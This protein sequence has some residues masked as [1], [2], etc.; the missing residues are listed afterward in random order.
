[1]EDITLLSSQEPVP[2]DTSQTPAVSS[3]SGSSNE[4]VHEDRSKLGRKVKN[5]EEQL[6]TLTR[7]IEEQKSLIEHLMSAKQQPE[8]Y[9]ESAPEEEIPDVPTTKDDVLKIIQYYEKKKTAEEMKRR[10]NYEKQY[11][12]TLASLLSSEDP[13]LRD[14]IYRIW[15]S[16]YNRVFTNDPVVDAEKGFLLA[17]VEALQKLSMSSRKSP[18]QYPTT[19]YST[20]VAGIELSPEARKLAKYLGFTEDDIREAMESKVIESSQHLIK[21]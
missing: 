8:Q 20:H 2:E 21:K 11:S 3:T 18:P 6:R 15:V 5:L 7:V 4:N 16:K 9:S 1:M 13:S 17:K 10:E 12:V 14:E 19:G